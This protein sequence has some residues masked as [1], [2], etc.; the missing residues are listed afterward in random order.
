MICLQSFSI[1][2]VFP[3]T[4]IGSQTNNVHS[5]QGGER[6]KA[7]SGRTDFIEIVEKI[8]K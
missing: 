5:L 2:S 7:K 6:E 3:L 1:L 8:K 4:L